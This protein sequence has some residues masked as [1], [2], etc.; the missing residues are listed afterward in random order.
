MI[1]DPIFPSVTF[2]T[3]QV[4]SIG[5]SE[6][7]LKAEGKAVKSKKIFFKS[8]A[9]AKIKGDDSGFIKVIYDPES[10]VILGAAIIG[11]DATELIHQFLIMINK[12][13][14]LG[15]IQEMVF[16]HPTLSEVIGEL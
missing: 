11:N 12:Q 13:V 3:P 4:A 6:A 5:A 14:T 7:D 15:E 10:E 8:N 16:A 2:S 1:A 9:K